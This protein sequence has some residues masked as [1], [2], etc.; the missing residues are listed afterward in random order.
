M[1]LIFALRCMFTIFHEKE[2]DKPVSTSQNGA[3]I[4]DDV[5]EAV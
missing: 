2:N 3:S 4:H 1:A 5:D